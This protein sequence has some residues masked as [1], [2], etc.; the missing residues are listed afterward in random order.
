MLSFARL[1]QAKVRAR[2][3]AVEQIR[4]AVKD[5]LDA[6]LTEADQAT[7]IRL[8]DRLAQLM[9]TEVI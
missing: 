2:R 6:R 4:Q 1:S 7:I 5:Y 8:A 3:L 9:V